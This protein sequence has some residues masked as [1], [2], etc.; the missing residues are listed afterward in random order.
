MDLFLRAKELGQTAIAVTD[1]GT[2]ATDWDSLKASKK[3]GV[4]LIM[5]S[6]FFFVEDLKDESKRIAQVVLLA[7]NHVGYR[8]IL[9]ATKLACDNFVVR[10]GKVLPRIDWSILEKCSEGV[11]CITAG[12]AGILSQLINT[13][14]PDEAFERAKRLKKIFGDNLAFE[15][16]PH[17]MVRE[18]NPYNDYEDQRLVNKK[19][20]QFGDKLGVKIIAA[21]EAQYL[22]KDQWESHD[23]L[24]SIGSGIP[25]RA[26]SRPRY[27]TKEFYV[28]TRAEVEKFFQRYFGDRAVEFCDNTLYFADMCEDPVWID[29]KFSNPS[30]KELP[31][32]PVKDQEDYWE[33]RH[34]LSSKSLNVQELDEDITYLRFW[35]TKSARTRV[36]V[37]KR[38][39]YKQ[40]I[41]KELDVIEKL[42]FSSYMLIVA[43]IIDFCAQ[44]KHPYGLGRGSVGGCFVAYLLDIHQADS[45]KYGLIFERFLNLDKKSYPDID[46][47][48]APYVKGL[49][50][51]YLVKKY[52]ADYVAQVSN[53]ITITPKVYSRDIARAF[54]FGGDRKSAVEIGTAI[55]DS[56][57]EH[58]HT[59]DVALE[60]APLFIEFTNSPY[61]KPLKKFA[62]DIGGLPRAWGMHAGGLVI[63]SRPLHHIV[64]LRR[65]KEGNLAIEYEKE[66]AEENGLVKIDIL[67]L[68]TL[69]V[70]AD[71]V[72]LIKLADKPEPDKLWDFDA[73]DE[74]AYDLICRGDTLCVFQLGKSG[75]TIDLCKKIQPRTL[76]DIAIINALARPSSR[77]IRADFILTKKG[78]KEIEILHPSLERAFGETYGFGLYEECLMYLAQDVAGWDLDK[79]DRLRVLTKAK[80]KYPKQVKQYRI[81]F[82]DDAVANGIPV[83]MVTNIW[84]DV[85]DKFQGYG[86]NKSHAIFYSMLGYQTAYLKAHYPVEFLT[87]NLILEDDSNAKISEKNI[88]RIKREMRLNKIEIAAPNINKSEM[89][90]EILDDVN[91]LTGFGSLK[92]MGKDGIPEILQHRPFHNFEDFL[93]RVDGR[94]VRVTAVQALAASGC[95]DG[96]GHTRKEMFLH[97]S[98]YKK[99][100]QAWNKK[101]DTAAKRAAKSEQEYVRKPFRYPWPEDTDEWSLAEKYAMEVYYLGEAFCCGSQQAYPDFF[102]NWGL[103]FSTLADIFP[104]PGDPNERYFIPMAD[105]VVEGIIID[106][107]EFSVKKEKSKIFGQ[108]MAKVDI[109]DKWGNIMPMTIFPGGLDQFNMRLRA[110]TSGKAK[111][112]PGIAV[113]CAA[114]ANWYGGDI[115]LIFDDLKKASCIPPKP[116]DLKHR[117]V[118]MRVASTKREKTVVLNPDRFLDQTEDELILEGFS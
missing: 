103:D 85:V 91:I 3:T 76:E 56:I 115:S 83:E 37:D 42:G 84:D 6:E 74:K 52:G 73:C 26:V 100:L 71:T 43:D 94:K 53:I 62:K 95:L 82:I 107:F 98:D 101:Q 13:R 79:A 88:S 116:Q 18:S 105:G 45:I 27:P 25:V 77:D 70:I 39:E 2:M 49:V 47:D 96:F 55:A 66:R 80:G 7:K 1:I 97:A 22:N 40:R 110:L 60:D 20:V 63:G 90:Y 112:E 36:P 11:I 67:G 102:D 10:F 14:R 38:P 104:D 35:C 48:F 64:P 4:K 9:L 93:S 81:E 41:I 111:L 72:K 86:F 118:S 28:K 8:N 57:P 29:P 17:S 99:K 51:Q 117:K 89:A 30:G 109:E 87:A 113:H 31:Q 21:T 69:Q 65:D 61:Y 24:L 34:W 54:S 106:Y 15:I 58:I 32:F 114:T 92:Y 12:G 33:Y 5:G 59:L 108:T 75:G 44:N 23:A 46:C 50:Q 78:E 68:S 19:L 16:Q